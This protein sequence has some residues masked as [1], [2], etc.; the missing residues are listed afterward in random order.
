ML[1]NVLRP[2]YVDTLQEDE[3]ISFDEANSYWPTS[4]KADDPFDSNFKLIVNVGEIT[5]N[6]DVV[7]VVLYKGVHYLFGVLEDVPPNSVVTAAWIEGSIP[8]IREF[9]EGLGGTIP[10]TTTIALTWETGYTT[11][12]GSTFY[13]T[14]EL[15]TSIYVE[16]PG[17]DWLTIAVV[18]G[19]IV[20]V[21]AI[22]YSVLKKP[23]PAKA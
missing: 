4:L 10:E 13:K 20:G 16:V 15:P 11:D 1:R 19:I 3:P 8:T 12:G 7:V 21:G 23:A 14:D 18:G 22:A 2:I 6:R 17:T 9:I 5:E